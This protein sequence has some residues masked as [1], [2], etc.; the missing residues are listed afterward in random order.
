MIIGIFNVGIVCYLS[1]EIL[2]FSAV[3]EKVNL[4]YLNQLEL[5]LTFLCIQ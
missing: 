3:Y 1:I 5:A 2:D 4:F